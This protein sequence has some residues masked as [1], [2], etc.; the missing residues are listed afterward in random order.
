MEPSG[1]PHSR[2][3]ESIDLRSALLELSK[4]CPFTMLMPI[5]VHPDVVPA[6]RALREFEDA[7][8]GEEVMRARWDEALAGGEYRWR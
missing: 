2:Q 8:G 1:A 5:R 3:R 7:V 4:G 6:L